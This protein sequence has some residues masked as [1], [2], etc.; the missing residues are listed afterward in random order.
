VNRPKIKGTA[1]ETD[2]VR[3]LQAHG[4]EAAERRA[5]SGTQDKGD[6]AG[7]PGVVIECKNHKTIDLGSW[8]TEL[9]REQT[10]A[11]AHLGLVVAKRR[12]HNVAQSYAVMT[13]EQAAYLIR[14]AAR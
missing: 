8:M 11:S 1:F 13:L 2:V 9:E 3:Y 14:G 7:I 6:V 4:F 10:R 5:L 12:M